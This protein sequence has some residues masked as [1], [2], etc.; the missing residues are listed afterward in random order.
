MRHSFCLVCVCVAHI[1]CSCCVL[2][3]LYLVFCALHM[4]GGVGSCTCVLTCLCRCHCMTRGVVHRCC[5]YV[6]SR[7]AVCCGVV[8][9]LYVYAACWSHITG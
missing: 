5:C 3:H 6:Y 7:D 2:S 4:G 8:G 9:C 1:L